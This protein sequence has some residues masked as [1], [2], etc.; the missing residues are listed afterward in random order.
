M[1]H[2]LKF[3]IYFYMRNTNDVNIFQSDVYKTIKCYNIQCLGIVQT[4]IIVTGSAV[5][6]SLLSLLIGS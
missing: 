1:I 2:A 4:G 3:Q 5:T 6:V